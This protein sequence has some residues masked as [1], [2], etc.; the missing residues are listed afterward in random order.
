M[1]YRLTMI[2][3]VGRKDDLA[4]AGALLGTYGR[5][6]VVGPGGIG[7][8]S[9]ARELVD[10]LADEQVVVE[11]DI[12]ARPGTIKSVAVDL[13]GGPRPGD[14]PDDAL[15]ARTESRRLALVLDG[16]DALVDQVLAI[17]D[18]VTVG[19]NGPW[20]VV[21]SRVY[22]T[23]TTWPVIRLDPLD[24]G[25]KS[26]AAEL[27]RAGFMAAGGDGD[28]LATAGGRLDRVLAASAGVPLA[29]EVAA[30]RAA[31]LGFPVGD[32]ATEVGP[33]DVVAQSVRRSLDGLPDHAVEV[34][35][36]LGVTSS[37]FPVS[38]AAAV[39]NLSRSRTV[40]WLAVLARHNLVRPGADGYALLPPIHRE[41]RRLAAARTSGA[42]QRHL[43]WCVGQAG[44]VHTAAEAGRVAP[45]AVDLSLAIE[46]ALADGRVDVAVELTL[47]LEDI[48]RLTMQHRR[49]LEV[50]EATV[51]ALPADRARDRARLWCRLGQAQADTVGPAAARSDLNRA[52]AALGDVATDDP[53]MIDIRRTRAGLRAEGG[54]PGGAVDTLLDVAALSASRGDLDAELHARRFAANA[55]LELGRLDEAE[56]QAAR[57]V[58]GA[59]DA[60]PGTR[61]LGLDSR[62]MIAL[63]KGDR[64]TCAAIGR[65]LA[66]DPVDDG[67]RVD[68][69]YLLLAADPTRHAGRPFWSANRVGE[70]ATAHEILI[71]LGRVIT[72]LV[73]GDAVTGLS[74]ASDAAMVA[75]ARGVAWGMVD[76]L[77]LAG[78]TAIVAA[79]P[80]QAAICHRQALAVATDAGFALRVPDALDG[81]ACVLT[82]RAAR[83][84]RST[85]ARIRVHHG[86]APRPR[87]WLPTPSTATG[88]APAAWL[89]EGALS[90]QG[91]AR[92]LD[93]NAQA[94]AA[95]THPLDLLSPAERRITDLVMEGCTNREIAQRLHVGRR[96][97]ETHL[98]HAFQKLDVTNRTQLAMVAASASPP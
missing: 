87:P 51:A 18:D 32:E 15:A 81:L 76:A 44:P 7:K 16:A 75:E 94:D 91:L 68:G 4:R 85:A 37:R 41:A 70:S 30:A 86:A 40:E 80:R 79:D 56:R 24:V 63:E 25:P 49:R 20:V 73:D 71:V 19:P 46:R 17:A 67:R 1:D 10:G 29:I 8:T 47:A 5:V 61:Q 38:L 89:V 52:E 83:E 36:A 39:A 21:T 12:L 96:T 93:A 84:A 43:A 69:E 35:A 77:L 53:M 42:E 33:D 64:A 78:D 22:P 92:F 55:L 59:G 98:L 97:V 9:L 27:F 65:M 34:F 54:D 48:L 58:I 3:L 2:E 95:G 6:V 57:V 74:M 31:I 82:V 62:A 11:A 45:F 23:A 66:D 90:L 60:S 72:L 14:D 28:L 26:P 13:V 50:L 88:T